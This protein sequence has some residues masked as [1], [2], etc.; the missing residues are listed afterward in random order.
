MLKLFI[1]RLRYRNYDIV[2][3]QDNNEVFIKR[4]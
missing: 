2:L 4:F 3:D 1:R